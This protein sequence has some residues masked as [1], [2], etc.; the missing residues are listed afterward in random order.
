VQGQ[1]R[2]WK[3][4]AVDKALGIKPFRYS[5]IQKVIRE[6]VQKALSAQTA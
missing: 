1:K 2:R 3:R 6:E 5:D 4:S